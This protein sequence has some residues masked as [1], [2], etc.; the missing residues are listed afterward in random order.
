VDGD[1]ISSAF[2][3]VELWT[4][5]VGAHDHELEGDDTGVDD[6]HMDELTEGFGHHVDDGEDEGLGHHVMPDEGVDHEL[7]DPVVDD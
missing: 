2:V 1:V 4:G 3:T 7:V 5:C 6:H